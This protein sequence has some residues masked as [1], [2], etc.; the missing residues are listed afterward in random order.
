MA[1]VWG[2]PTGGVLAQ[3]LKHNSIVQHKIDNGF[4]FS[5]KMVSYIVLA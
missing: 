4:G 2:F 5:A 3:P 1:A